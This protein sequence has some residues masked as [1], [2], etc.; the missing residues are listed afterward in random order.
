MPGP[1]LS[2]LHVF[3]D[4]RG[5]WPC[6]HHFAGG[7]METERLSEMLWFTQQVS[8]NARI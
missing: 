6:Y 3:I 7:K 2:I 4:L 8:G 1:V 5:R